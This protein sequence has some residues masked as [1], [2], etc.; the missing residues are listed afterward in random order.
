MEFIIPKPELKRAEANKRGILCGVIT[1]I[2]TIALVLSPR[3][4]NNYTLAITSLAWPD[5]ATQD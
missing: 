2:G 3:V 5:L 1:S 4:Y